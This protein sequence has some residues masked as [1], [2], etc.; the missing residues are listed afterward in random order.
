MFAKLGNFLNIKFV[1]IFIKNS[2]NVLLFIKNFNNISFDFFSE[3]KSSSK[4]FFVFGNQNNDYLKKNQFS[5]FK[6]YFLFLKV[7]LKKYDLILMLFSVYFFKYY[8]LIFLERSNRQIF[9]N[10]ILNNKLCKKY[11]YIYKKFLVLFISLKKILCYNNDKDKNKINFLF[12]NLFSKLYVI[13]KKLRFKFLSFQLQKKDFLKFNFKIKNKFLNKIKKICKYLFF[14][15]V[16]LNLK[17]KLSFINKQSQFQY[18]YKI[19]KKIYLI[20]EII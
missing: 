18:N 20:N 5:F 17:Y 6:D 9:T 3:T 14:K 8:R 7:L 11:K 2:K 10:V 12:K 1:D 19:K 15:K 16:F 4:N 13:F